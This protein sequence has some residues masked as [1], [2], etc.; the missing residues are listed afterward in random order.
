MLTRASDVGPVAERTSPLSN[1]VW[2]SAPNGSPPEPDSASVLAKLP[3]TRPQRA[4]AR[5]DAARAA[6]AA[7]APP[8]A[9]P[10]RA[11]GRVHTA[12]PSPD[13]ALRRASARKPSSRQR[14]A[15][16][17]TRARGTAGAAASVPQ[18]PPAPRQGFECEGER[19]SRTVYPP[20]GA[21]LVASALEVVGELAKAGLSSGERLLRDAL[22]R[23]PLP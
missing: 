19:Q 1:D 15:A 5:R 14:S 23:L 16:T 6:G 2:M 9:A 22:S 4:S 21:E 17:R 13:A 8:S 12:A 3:R 10:Q 7:N 11:N 20:G 18:L